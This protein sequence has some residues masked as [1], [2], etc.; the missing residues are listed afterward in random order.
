M[1]NEVARLIHELAVEFRQLEELAA[2]LQQHLKNKV[3]KPSQQF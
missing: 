1:K 2:S 3:H